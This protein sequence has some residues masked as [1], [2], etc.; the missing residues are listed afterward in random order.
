MIGATSTHVL[1]SQSWSRTNVFQ[2]DSVARGT[3]TSAL[4]RFFL[5]SL[6]AWLIHLAFG[7]DK[8]AHVTLTRCRRI[9]PRFKPDTW[10]ESRRRLNEATR[11]R[12]DFHK[13]ELLMAWLH[14]RATEVEEEIVR[15]RAFSWKEW[16]AAKIAEAGSPSI[17]RYMRNRLSWPQFL[18]DRMLG[19]CCSPQGD[20]N[21]RAKAWHNR[22]SI[23]D[24][25]SLEWQ[26]FTKADIDM[27]D[28]PDFDNFRLLA[29]SFSTKTATGIC[30]THPRHFCL[31]SAGAYFGDDAPMEGYSSV[32]QAS[33]TDT[34]FNHLP[35]SQGSRG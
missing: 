9:V 31:T 3:P 33:Q 22:W 32:G 23:H 19:A 10:A 20:A 15:S 21:L 34:A 16:C 6:R 1:V 24:S 14:E 4:W 18:V 29:E 12:R 35:H 11:G 30:G 13:V 25:P 17:H 27:V 8:L 26:V 2:K 5:S 28:L 7:N